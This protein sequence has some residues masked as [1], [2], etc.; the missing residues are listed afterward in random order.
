[1]MIMIQMQFF[2]FFNT[3]AQPLNR[4]ISFGITFTIKIYGY[5]INWHIARGLLNNQGPF[6]QT[7]QNYYDFIFPTLA[8]L[9]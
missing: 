6:V 3:G 4:Y 5:A 7:L 1:M 9:S 8:T 2:T